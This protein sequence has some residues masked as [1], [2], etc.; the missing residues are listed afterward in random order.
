MGFV[1]LLPP[2]VAGEGRVGGHF[3]MLRSFRHY[4]FR[5]FFIGEF[6]SFVGTWMQGTA[7]M[8]LVYRLT[9]SPF[10]LGLAAFASQA[11]FLFFGLLGGAVADRA[12]KRRVLVW[13]QIAFTLQAL[14]LAWLTITGRVTVAQILVLALGM[15]V[16][17]S[18]EMPA[19]QAFLARMVPRADLPNAIALNSMLV[20]GSR[21]LG[22]IL[23]GL[24]AGAWGEGACFF[25]NGVSYL[26]VLASLA[27][28]RLQPEDTAG[29]ADAE[30]P[31]DAIRRGIDYTASH[32]SMRAV[33][34]L[35][36]LSSLAGTPY[37]VLL[38][39]FAD[40]L[41]V[42]VKGLGMLTGAI[43]A[44]ALIGGVMLARRE[45]HAGLM[46]MVGTAA[47]GFGATVAL[48]ALSSRLDFSLVFLTLTGW[49]MMITYVG[50]NTLLQ[51]LSSDGM[52]GRVMSLFSMT[53]MGFSPIGNLLAGA[54][55]QRVGAPATLV[56]GGLACA[57]GGVLFLALKGETT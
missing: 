52:R 13:T 20:N 36:A 3:L 40:A 24:A 6:I 48:F 1:L 12:D 47:I 34:C 19:R 49:G 25:L 43:G 37:I 4:N 42:G 35:L 38:P 17:N 44:G 8:W 9:R 32:P 56:A 21:I 41:G 11:P 28:M 26:A 50:S 18:F 57:A 27:L 46:G 39:V 54:A 7:Q 15:G 55:S 45:H 14:L 2:P 53:F 5:L 33:L 10:L 22:P 23:A 30:P 51:S 31:L 16:T 29:K